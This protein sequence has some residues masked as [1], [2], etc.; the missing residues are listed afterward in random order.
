MLA[1]ASIGAIWSSCSPDFGVNGVLDR[2]GQIQ[3]KVLF[4]APS[5]RYAGKDIDCLAR[6]QEIVNRPGWVQG[7]AVAF[8]IDGTGRRTA[9]AKDGLSPAVLVLQYRLQ[10]P[11]TAPVVGAG[12]A[13]VSSWRWRR[14]TTTC[15]CTAM[16]MP[17]CR[18]HAADVSNPSRLPSTRV[19]TCASARDRPRPPCRAAAPA[20]RRTTRA[21]AAGVSPLNSLRRGIQRGAVWLAACLNRPWLSAPRTVSYPCDVPARPENVSGVHLGVLAVAGVHPDHAGLVAER[22]RAESRRGALV[23]EC[24]Q[25]PQSCCGVP[26]SYRDARGPNQRGTIDR[27]Q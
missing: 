20:R 4:S 23:G 26:G 22:R 2:F 3:P 15:W 10:P 25:H 8:M 13:G 7:N 14:G 24:R 1:T 17:P 27:R 18:R 6:V 9:E 12:R 16:S 5:Y 21:R 19:S 11:N